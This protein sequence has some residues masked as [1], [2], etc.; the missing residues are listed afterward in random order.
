MKHSHEIGQSSNSETAGI[1]ASF[2]KIWFTSY[3]TQIEMLQHL[4]SVKVDKARNLQPY[5]DKFQSKM[6]SNV[7]KTL[8]DKYSFRKYLQDMILKELIT[9]DKSNPELAKVVITP[10]AEDF[11]NYLSN[12][13]DLNTRP[14]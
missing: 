1:K 14:L 7:V 9:I 12:K 13:D 4:S 6:V 8:R 2:E 5:F 11:I 10:L 3:G